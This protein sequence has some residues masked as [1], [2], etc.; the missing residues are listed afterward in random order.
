[1]IVFK[2][3]ENIVYIHIYIF[4]FFFFFHFW[5]ALHGLWILVPYTGIEPVPSA[6]KAWCCNYCVAREFPKILYFK[7]TF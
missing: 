6:V 5:V 7:A 2:R 4:F 1:M 3:H